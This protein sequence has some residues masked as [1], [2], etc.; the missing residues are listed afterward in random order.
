[1]SIEFPD[2]EVKEKNSKESPAVE[3]PAPAQLQS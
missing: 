1:M 3:T 2:K